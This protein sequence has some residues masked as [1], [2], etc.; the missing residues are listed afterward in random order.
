V[1]TTTNNLNAVAFP[2]V[3]YGW[4]V[5]A[6]G[7]VV[8]YNACTGGALSLTAPSSISFPARTLSAGDQTYSTTA[9]VTPDDETG[10]SGGWTLTGYAT[11]FSDGNG[12]TLP[13]PSISAAA[14]SA[15]ASTCSMPSS[16]VTYPTPPLGGSDVDATPIFDAAP[17]S[18]AGPVDI[19]L[20]FRQTL[21]AN[22]LIGTSPAIFTSV[23]TFAVSTGP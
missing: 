13:P 17:G 20:T 2:S 22:Q 8:A 14:P 3:A 9:V 15:T 7:T 23:V 12:H 10:A 19:S 16:G 5:G 1:S 6:S 4:A 18:G 21:P 11:S